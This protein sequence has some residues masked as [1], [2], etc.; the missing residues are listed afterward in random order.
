MFSLSFSSKVCIN[1]G[2][3]SS[4]RQ[5]TV[6]KLSKPQKKQSTV[7]NN[8]PTNLEW[9][10]KCK[11]WR[12]VVN[13]INDNR[14]PCTKSSINIFNNI[15][16]NAFLESDHALGWELLHKMSQKNFQPNCESFSA[17]WHY[18][19]LHQETF[20]ANVEQMF[21]FINKNNVI[22][23]KNVIEDLSNK[24][25]HFGG[26]C[27]PSKMDKIGQC[28]S[29][30][31]Q[32]PPLQQ[33][34]LEFNTLKREFEKVLKPKI[35]SIELAFFRQIVNK[36]KIFDYAIDSLNVTRIFPDFK[37]NLVKQGE[38]LAKIV[39]QL[40]SNNK[41]VIV[42]GKKHVEKIPESSINLIRRNAT[43]YLTKHNEAID[44]LFMMY[45]IFVSGSKAHFVTNDFLDEYWMEFSENGKIL[46]RNWQIQHQH[47]VTYDPKTDLVHINAPKKFICNAN[48]STET[49]QWHIP[50]T[51][52]PLLHS[53]RGF[54]PIPI[55]W[56]C[57]NFKS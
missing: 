7:G 34:Q 54:I 36:K 21:E 46:F 30:N 20:A 52:R 8:I 49:G 51:Q 35:P 43:V 15:A 50:F 29:C 38:I 18:C 14:I 19:A 53:L 3:W 9:L 1:L 42:I 2:K 12:K 5:Y 57:I 10:S 16:V 45:A 4:I 48:K 13:I 55:E 40:R 39:K 24:I 25:Q 23:S 47:F 27:S 44:D 56:A 11:D 28:S 22:V 26:I 32:M 37:G 6:N 17:Y 41:R 33:S 31:Y